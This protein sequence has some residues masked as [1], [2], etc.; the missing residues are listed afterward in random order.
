MHPGVKALLRS[1]VQLPYRHARRMRFA[2]F[3]GTGDAREARCRWGRRRYASCAPHLLVERW[4]DYLQSLNVTLFTAGDT[5]VTV[6]TVLGLLASVLA[7]LVFSRWLRNRLVVRVLDRSPL[8]PGTRQ[9]V[10][11]LVY[12]V[13]VV[14]GLTVIMQNAGL[15]LS[16]FSLLAGAIGVGIGFGLQNIVSNFISGLIVMLERPVR[17][18]DR[19]EI[20]GMEGDV[21]AINA[22]S[23]VLRTSRGAAAIVP[24]QKFITELV[25][26]WASADGSTSLQIPLKVTREQ[27][28][29]AVHEL[30][31]EAVR[32]AAATPD[33]AGG[34]SE[35][36]PAIYCTAL[37]AG[38]CSYELQA[39]V[40][41]SPMRRAQL[42]T[43]LLLEIQKLVPERGVR[44]A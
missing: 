5:P 29:A 16:A 14:I 15:K 18:G 22:R 30:L 10:A 38:S 37:D 40:H 1:D 27:D 4:I 8:D 6:G 33:S 21:V 7:L 17:I 42:Q 44:L 34:F 9:A 3:A 32:R 35:R 39:W 24:N 26:N 36:E 23:T 2:R 19:I 20:G 25:R 11:S 12:Y 13:V 31:V 28:A 43:S 41:G